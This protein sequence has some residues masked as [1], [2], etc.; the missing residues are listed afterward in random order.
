LEVPGTPPVAGRGGTHPATHHSAPKCTRGES[1]APTPSE[2]GPGCGAEPH[3]SFRF[4][5]SCCAPAPVRAGRRSGTKAGAAAR[6]PGGRRAAHAR[7][8]EPV[9]KVVTQSG[10]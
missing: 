8:L 2:R 9:E 7:R 6:G 3:E 10:V 5:A 4:D 1:Q